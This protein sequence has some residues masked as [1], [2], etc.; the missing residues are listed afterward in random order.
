M[1]D[2]SDDTDIMES[3]K[4]M[5]SQLAVPKHPDTPNDSLDPTPR[6]GAVPLLPVHV[7]RADMPELMLSGALEIASRAVQKGGW[8]NEIAGRIKKHMDKKFQART[9]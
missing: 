1:Q 3:H 7:K 5:E 6:S 2:L 4:V 8:D 9:A